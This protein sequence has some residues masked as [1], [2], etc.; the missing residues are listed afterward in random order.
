ML[1]GEGGVRACG[2]SEPADQGLELK[3]DTCLPQLP[4]SVLIAIIQL[5]ISTNE[6]QDEPTS[7]IYMCVVN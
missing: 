6:N 3:Q 4:A 2:N 7:S 1:R 5:V